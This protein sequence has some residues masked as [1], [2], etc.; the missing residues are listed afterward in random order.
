MGIIFFSEEGICNGQG[1][2][3]LVLAE[4]EYLE[5]AAAWAEPNRKPS[6]QMGFPGGW[7][8]KWPPKLGDDL[9]L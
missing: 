4:D 6:E 1:I 9:P 2:P 5:E 3:P 8:R 7:R